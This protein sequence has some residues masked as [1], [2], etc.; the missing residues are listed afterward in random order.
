MHKQ[1]EKQLLPQSVQVSTGHD[2]LEAESDKLITMKPEQLS[3]RHATVTTRKPLK[4]GLSAKESHPWS[5]AHVGSAFCV[6]T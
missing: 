1:T 4:D 2:C 3:K 5:T 6:P